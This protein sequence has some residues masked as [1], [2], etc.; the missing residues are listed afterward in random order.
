MRN[1]LVALLVLVCFFPT[2]A[3]A[4]DAA[5]KPVIRY[6]TEGNAVRSIA[7]I[8]INF[9][10]QR[11]R[12]TT[13]ARLGNMFFNAPDTDKLSDSLSSYWNVSSYGREQIEGK[14]FGLTPLEDKPSCN[15]SLASDWARQVIAYWELRGENLEI[16]DHLFLVMPHRSSCDFGGFANMPGK[17][18]VINQWPADWTTARTRNS[19]TLSTLVH[20]LLHNRG[21]GHS[22]IVGCVD[23][24]KKTS[25]GGEC[26]ETDRYKYDWDPYEIMTSEG[27]WPKYLPNSFQ[28]IALG[29]ITESEMVR[30]SDSGTHAVLLNPIEFSSSLTKALV[31]RRAGLPL[32]FTPTYDALDMPTSSAPDICIE[33]HQPRGWFSN[34]SLKSSVAQGISMRLCDL[35]SVGVEYSLAEGSSETGFYRPGTRLIDATPGSKKGKA[36]WTDAQL[37]K[38]IW[39][40]AFTGITVRV[41]GLNKVGADRS[42]WS[43]NLEVVIP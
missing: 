14:V 7:V 28:R 30:L 29:F 34:F 18:I 31:I 42:T 20:E 2:E 24:G 37:S 10:G 15:R 13:Q 27:Y 26:N 21:F 41:L 39:S 3:Q 16:Y 5:R 4:A 40:D 38:G 33:W 32:F 35:Y 8:P 11:I 6:T 12:P 36:D 43:I 1:A 22:G 19:I 9:S 23:N 25:L 17:V